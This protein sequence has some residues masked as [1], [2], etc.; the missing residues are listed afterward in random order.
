MVVD[1]GQATRPSIAER[2]IG[3]E[4]AAAGAAL[5]QSNLWKDAWR[6]YIRNR[7]AVFAGAVFVLLVLYCLLWPFVSPYDP[8]AVD[9]SLKSQTPSLEHPF[10]T[11]QFGRDLLTRTALGG[12]LSIGIGIAA[13]LA[14]LVIGVVYG[15]ISGFVGGI[16][17]NVLMRFL[18][19]L[20]G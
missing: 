2:E 16:V 6:R 5:R 13:T 12:R 3:R 9:F 7:G 15:A 1:P 18:D 17:D 11:D 10:G 4:E 14:I 20:Y 19:T 8:N